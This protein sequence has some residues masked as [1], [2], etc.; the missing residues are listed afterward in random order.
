MPV[1]G[2]SY[3]MGGDALAGL[4]L[5]R[6]RH[7]PVCGFWHGGQRAVAVADHAV[8]LEVGAKEEFSGHPDKIDAKE[9]RHE[10]HDKK[11]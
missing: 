10:E 11:L 7:G 8:L 6:M 5:L 1:I 4:E 3:V 9:N 2:D